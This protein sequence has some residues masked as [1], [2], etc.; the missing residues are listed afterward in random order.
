MISGNQLVVFSNNG[1]IIASPSNF[2]PESKFIDNGYLFEISD[3]DNDELSN[4]VESS[5]CSVNMAFSDFLCFSPALSDTDSD[6]VKDGFENTY[7]TN[8]AANPLTPY[9]YLHRNYIDHDGVN[10]VDT[11]RDVNNNGVIDSLD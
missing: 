5:L 8:D 11:Y 3:I 7:S 4:D 2:Y 1:S 9:S 10:I 6:L